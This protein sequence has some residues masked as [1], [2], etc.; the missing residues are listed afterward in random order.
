MKTVRCN[1]FETNSSS[2]H[3]LTLM[4]DEEWELLEN[5]QMVC[6][7]YFERR[8]PMTEVVKEAIEKFGDRGLTEEMFNKIYAEFAEI[9]GDY[10]EYIPEAYDFED[11][12]KNGID[13]EDEDEDEYDEDEDED[14]SKNHK[15]SVVYSETDADIEEI[16]TGVRPAVVNPVEAIKNDVILWLYEN[17]YFNYKMLHIWDTVVDNYNGVTA[18]GFEGQQQCM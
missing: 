1:V 14:E 10:Y 12:F 15:T 16:I 17:Q 6:N 2:M 7:V 9:I 3:S 18:I 13:D 5:D 8:K 4:S 11:E